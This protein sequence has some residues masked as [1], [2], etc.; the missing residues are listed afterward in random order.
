[1]YRQA[2][3]SF[4]KQKHRTKPLGWGKGAGVEFREEPDN[5]SNTRDVKG[6]HERSG[7]RQLFGTC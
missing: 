2:L 1:M 6:W 5:L 4:L 7:Q 3:S